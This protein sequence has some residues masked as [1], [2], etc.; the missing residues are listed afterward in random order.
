MFCKRMFTLSIVFLVG[1]SALFAEENSVKLEELDGNWHLR[2]IDGKGA[3]KARAILEF[4][5]EKMAI[6]GFDGCNK[7]SGTLIAPSDSNMSSNLIATKMACRRPIHVQASK[8]LHDTLAEG[9]TVVRATSNGV[10]G[11]LIKSQHHQLFFKQ[12]GNEDKDD[13]GWIPDLDLDFDLDFGFDSDSNKS[14]SNTS[15]ANKTT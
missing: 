15:D 13:S 11:V 8:A 1:S 9:F 4:D 6:S 3:R 10:D 2:N 12:M 14:D 7:I 5:S